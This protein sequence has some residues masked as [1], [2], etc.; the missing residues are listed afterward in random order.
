MASSAVQ[1]IPSPTR[2]RQKNQKSPTNGL[3]SPNP[4]AMN[5]ID[6]PELIGLGRT[7]RIMRHGNIAV[8]TVNIW[9]VPEDASE[10][11]KIGAEL[12]NEVN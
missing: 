8:K 2:L 7:G 6:G 12:M 10:T 9:T 11:T 5:N 3:S 1:V 4:S